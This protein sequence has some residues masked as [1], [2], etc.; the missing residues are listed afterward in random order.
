MP[1][2]EKFDMNTEKVFDIP[3]RTKEAVFRSQI[4]VRP[5]LIYDTF[6]MSK[7]NYK[8]ALGALYKKKADCS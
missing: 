7:K 8:K 1:G 2:V 4:K 3:E 6:A 5:E